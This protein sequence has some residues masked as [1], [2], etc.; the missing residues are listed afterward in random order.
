MFEDCVSRKPIV[1]STTPVVILKGHT[2]IEFLLP[3]FES[4]LDDMKI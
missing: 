4:L 3:L 1:V 2:N